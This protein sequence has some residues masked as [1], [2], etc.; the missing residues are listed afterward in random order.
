M[1]HRG[2]PTN[3]PTA[4]KT[5][6]AFRRWLQAHHKTETELILRCFKVHAAHKGITYSQALDEA[7]C[8]GWIDGVRRALD[9]DSF[10]QRF[11]PRRPKSNWSDVN[12]RHVERLMSEGRMKPPGLA[13]FR[14]REDAR[15]GVYAFER[16]AAA[17]PDESLA[18]FRAHERAWT[19]FAAQA[20]WY[21]RTCA[22]WVM[23][24]KRDET[25][26]KRLA[27]VIDCSSRQVP[28]PALDRRT[29]AAS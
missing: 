2:V 1:I 8:W 19:Y 6:S 25:R 26:A 11:T 23:S 3:A 16:K 17:F 24:A 7:L 20:A 10:T 22:H 21:Q 27:I 29:P 5:P 13:A 28:I 9:E 14:G 18:T 12:V 15:T 4:F